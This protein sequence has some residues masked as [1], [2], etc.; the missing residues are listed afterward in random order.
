MAAETGRFPELSVT[1]PE[2]DI[3]CQVTVSQSDAEQGEREGLNTFWKAYL[4]RGVAT[5]N[6]ISSLEWQNMSLGEALGQANQKIQ[7]SD[8]ASNEL[9]A[10]IRYL[11]HMWQNSIKERTSAA[12]ALSEAK[13]AHRQIQAVLEDV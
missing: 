6:Y 3:V 4:D 2:Q 12:T 7:E 13:A 9:E 5:Q 10:H 8:S 1:L 11:Q